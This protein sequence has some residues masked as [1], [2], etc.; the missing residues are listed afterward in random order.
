[1][2]LLQTVSPRTAPTRTYDRPVGQRPHLEVVRMAGRRASQVPFVVLGAVLLTLGLLAA[3]LLNITLSQGSYALNDLQDTSATLRDQAAALRQDINAVSSPNH[4]ATK[5]QEL[6]MGPADSPAFL[7]P[8]TGKVSGV[9][10]PATKTAEFTVVS[11]SQAVA[12][13]ARPDDSTMAAASAV[14]GLGLGNGLV[15]GLAGLAGTAATR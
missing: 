13:Q 14:S 15:G 7:D 11:G 9:A 4:L 12:P 10:K 5:A 6:G 8:A 3:L 1:M 2:S